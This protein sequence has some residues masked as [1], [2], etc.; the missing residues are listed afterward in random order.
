MG[1]YSATQK[2]YKPGPDELVNVESHLNYN[3]RRA[4]TRV[5]AL[6]EFIPTDVSSISTSTL[7]AENGFKWYKRISNSFYIKTPTS[8]IAQYNANAQVPSWSTSGITFQGGYKSENE[9]ESK[10]SYSTEDGG[11]IVRWRGKLILGD[12]QQIPRNTNIIVANIPASVTPYRSKYIHTQMGNAGGSF[13]VARLLFH[14]LGRIEICRMGSDQTDPQERYISF[15]S[16]FYTRDD[17]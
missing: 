5:K 12:Y 14:S 1:E 3:M 9:F 13:S 17:L 4:D 2:F 10:I 16:C 6:V 11:S 15:N 8:G 7:E